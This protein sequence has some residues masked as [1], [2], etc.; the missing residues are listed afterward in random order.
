MFRETGEP[1]GLDHKGTKNSKVLSR[2]VQQVDRKSVDEAF[3]AIFQQ[4]DV[5]VDQRS[6]SQLAQFQV[7]RELGVVERRQLLDGLQFDDHA[8]TD[9]NIQ[10]QSGVEPNR[11]IDHRQADL[12][13]ERDVAFRRDPPAHSARVASEV[14]GQKRAAPRGALCVRG[15]AA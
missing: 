11:I 5:E 14:N 3:Q 9:E 1:D 4:M 2:S 6:K 7:G 10:S 8:G 12:T 15:A 13:L